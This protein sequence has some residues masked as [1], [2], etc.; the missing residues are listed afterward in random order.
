MQAT[1]AQGIA[2]TFGFS[3]GV[4]VL[5]RAQVEQLVAGAPFADIA[6]TEQTR[7]LVTFLPA[8]P[9]TAL[10]LP[11]HAPDH[12]VTILRVTDSEVC[13]VLTLSAATKTPDA[14]HLLETLFGPNITT[15]TWNTVVKLARL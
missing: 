10:D 6:V 12:A 4:I 5:P 13:S 15:R 8:P 9:Q 3:V 11:Y 7:L 14:M 2:A 1:I